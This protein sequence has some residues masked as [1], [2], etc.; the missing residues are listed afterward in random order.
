LLASF[1]H[2]AFSGQVEQAP[3][4]QLFA[5]GSDLGNV[6]HEDLLGDGG[7]HLPA[8]GLHPGNAEV[9]QSNGM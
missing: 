9:V 8:A 5:L 6:P 3:A 2:P 1:L 4:G 7:L